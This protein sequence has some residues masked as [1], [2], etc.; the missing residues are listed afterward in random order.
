MTKLMIGDTEVLIDG[1]REQIMFLAQFKWHMSTGGYPI[2]SFTESFKT[3][4]TVGMHRLLMMPIPDGMQVDH[5]NRI[6]TD[7]R[8]ENLRIV[9]R[10][11]NSR[12]VPT[13]NNKTSS[14]RGV[15]WHAKQG[16]WQVV[17][18]INGK[19]KWL[20]CY[21]SEHEAGSVAAPYFLDIAA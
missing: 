14:Y 15:S 21:E 7:N 6:K 4:R 20:G 18:K 11:M 13:R 17:V 2:T 10:T 8:L 12:N 3:P 1:G 19:L 5:I 16:K 9:S